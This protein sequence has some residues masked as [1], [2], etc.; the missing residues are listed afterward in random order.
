MRNTTYNRIYKSFGK[1]GLPGYLEGKGR[2]ETET[3]SQG[4]VHQIRREE[5]VPDE[6][7]WEAL[8]LQEIIKHKI[9]KCQKLERIE[10]NIEDIMKDQSDLKVEKWPRK[11]EKTRTKCR[12]ERGEIDY[13]YQIVGTLSSRGN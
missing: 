6:R 2:G 3:S 9:E 11:V 13:H 12:K 4:Q 10:L 5:Q 1:I 8:C 7:R